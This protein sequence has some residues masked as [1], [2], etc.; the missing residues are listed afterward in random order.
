MAE[1]E[2]FRARLASLDTDQREAVEAV[3]RGVLAKL[4][5]EPTIRLKESAGTPDGPRLNEA[6]RALFDL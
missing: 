4:L 1:I 6:L 2:R 3:T 5:H